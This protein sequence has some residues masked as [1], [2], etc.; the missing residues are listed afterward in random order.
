MKQEMIITIPDALYSLMRECES[1]C[2]AGCCGADA[3]DVTPQ[4]LASWCKLQTDDYIADRRA[5]FVNILSALRQEKG[6]VQITSPD[7]VETK[8]ANEWIEW[9][10]KWLATFDAAIVGAKK[11]EH[12]VL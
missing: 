10:E 9:F 2:V 3:F 11:S 12:N 5:E 8:H 4:P 1:Y 7:L 6:Q